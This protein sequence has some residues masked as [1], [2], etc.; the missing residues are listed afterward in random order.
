[1]LKDL[2]AILNV[3]KDSV[4]MLKPQD[5]PSAIGAR[6]L[7]GGTCL[8]LMATTPTSAIIMAHIVASLPNEHI[9]D[10]TAEFTKS[11]CAT[12]VGPSVDELHYMEL[13]RRTVYGLLKEPRLFQMPISWA[14]FGQHEGDMT[15]TR[16]Q[17]S[18]LKVFQHL[19]TKLN[20]SSSGKRSVASVQPRPGR[21]TVVVVRHDDKMPEIYLEDELAY[22][23]VPSG[24][25]ALVLDR[26]GLQQIDLDH[27]NGHGHG[28]P[29]D[30]G[31][32]GCAEH[33]CGC[34]VRRS[35]EP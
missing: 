20:I 17:E 29:G 24:S 33:N 15:L 18:T 31:G 4:H 5:T 16:L 23:L 28:D 34:N 3:S 10:S 11:R 12:S 30:G 14:F 9:Y 32:V 22:P 26:L 27:D 6:E 25:L 19:N 1:M 35:T 13:V 8:L 2:D 21:H 7:H